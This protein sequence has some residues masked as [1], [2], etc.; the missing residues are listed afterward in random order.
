MYISNSNFI[1]NSSRCNSIYSIIIIVVVILLVAV[2]LV[3]ITLAD[4]L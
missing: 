1:L 4:A 3:I 2:T